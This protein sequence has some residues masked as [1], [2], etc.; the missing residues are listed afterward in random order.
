MRP[1]SSSKH[2]KFLPDLEPNL[3]PDP[4]LDPHLATV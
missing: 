3:D 4:D 2:M 1:L